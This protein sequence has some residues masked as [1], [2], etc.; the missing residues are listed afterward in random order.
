MKVTLYDAAIIAFLFRND[1]NVLH[2]NIIGRDFK[3]VH[4][5]ISDLYNLALEDHD[6]FIE[7]AIL[8]EE[9]KAGPNM[10]EILSNLNKTI[11]KYWKPIEGDISI[12]IDNAFEK[13]INQ[14][15]DYSEVYD[16]LREY[17]ES[18]GFNDIVS[19]IDAMKSKWSIEIN[20]KV[21]RSIE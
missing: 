4:E 14:W 16:A 10:T 15:K 6:Y 19:D 2:W 5:Y 3:D 21:K 18:K 12:S 17:C 20:Y 9:I 7:H 1:L 11:G 13:I 8:T